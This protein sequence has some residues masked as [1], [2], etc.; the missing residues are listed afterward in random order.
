MNYRL[1]SFGFL[2]SKELLAAQKSGSGTLN[3][4]LH[5]IQAALV[6]VQKNIDKFGG[7]PT[8]VCAHTLPR[9]KQAV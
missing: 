5:D 3:A 6:W 2:A 8:K 1:N 7:D 9:V 4:G